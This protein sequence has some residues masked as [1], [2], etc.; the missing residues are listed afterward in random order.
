MVSDQT[1]AKGGVGIG[2]QPSLQV[3]SRGGYSHVQMRHRPLRGPPPLSSKFHVPF[4]QCH[5]GSMSKT[6]ISVQV[7]CNL[8]ALNVFG[9]INVS[10]TTVFCSVLEL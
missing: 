5:S 3:G 4:S 8:F 9:K 10:L 7:R 6:V 1:Q 2:A